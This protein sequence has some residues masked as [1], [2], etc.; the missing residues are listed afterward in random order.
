MSADVI[1]ARALGANGQL[2]IGNSTLSADRL[3][4][5]YAPGSNGQLNFIANTTLSSGSRIDLAG[6]TV[7]IQ[8]SVAVLVIGNGGPANVYTNNPNYNTGIPGV[9]NPANGSFTG[10][11]ANAPLPLAV[12]PGFDD[13][14]PGTSSH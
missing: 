8:P 2:N 11:G 5:L 1:K 6:S 13:P 9:G 12:A 10:N 7:T 4:R 14:P 3:I